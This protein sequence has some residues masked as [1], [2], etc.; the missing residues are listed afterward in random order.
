MVNDPDTH[1]GSPFFTILTASLN[2][3]HALVDTL[4]SVRNQRFQDLEH[5][6]S[7][8]GSGDGTPDLLR[9][10][11]STYNL[12]WESQPDR[13]IAHALNRGLSLS[14]GTYVLV[15]HADDRLLDPDALSFAHRFLS[16]IPDGIGSFPVL[17]HYPGRG[18]KPYRPVRL[19][20]WNHFKTILPHQGAFV[21]RGVFRRIGG[22][23]ERYRIGF[24]YDFFYRALKAGVPVRFNRRPVAEMGGAGIS[25]DPEFLAERLSEERQVQELNERDPFWKAAQRI[26]RRLYL[27]YKTRM[28]P[29]LPKTHP[30]GD[31][32]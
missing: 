28:R 20:W 26:F 17:K 4:A 18:L 31:P 23:R 3:R 22:F 15:L 24:D 5:V 8:G 7:D 29:G 2:N 10:S 16:R 32:L 11:E 30:K 25:S 1:R 6:V 19:L 12:I 9:E 21:H 13:G 14:R 27:P